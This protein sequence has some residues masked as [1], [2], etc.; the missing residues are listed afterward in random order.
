MTQH[1]AQDRIVFHVSGPD[2]PGVTARIAEIVAQVNGQLVDIGQSVLHGYLTLSAIV[3]IPPESAAL[4][5]ILFFASELGLR[6]EV[7]RFLPSEGSRKVE[8]PS[9]LCVTV[10]GQ[11]AD[12]K[13]VSAITRNMAARGM[14]ILEMFIPTLFSATAFIT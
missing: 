13:A 14:N 7:S 8:P 12:G 3:E 2:R 9:G 1:H 11:L 5:Q 6:L 4:R 10:L